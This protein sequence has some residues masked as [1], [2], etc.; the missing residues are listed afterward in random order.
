MK[1][2]WLPTEP[3][4]PAAS[5]CPAN[6]TCSE[7]QRTPSATGAAS[8]RIG[9]SSD[10]GRSGQ[11][12]SLWTAVVPVSSGLA[13]MEARCGRRPRDATSATLRRDPAP[14]MAVPGDHA[15]HGPSVVSDGIQE[16]VVDPAA[17]GG[18]GSVAGGLS[19]VSICGHGAGTGTHVD[20]RAGDPQPIAQRQLWLCQYTGVNACETCCPKICSQQAR[21]QEAACGQA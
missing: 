4:A 16:P 21:S 18:R 20:D 10:G 9:R 11:R 17:G 19:E 13:R 5:A 2:A 8:N 15:R 3:L 6:V 14:K 7:L 1:L 12:G